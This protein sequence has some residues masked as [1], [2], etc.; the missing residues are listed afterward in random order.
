MSIQF[1]RKLEKSSLVGNTSFSHILQVKVFGKSGFDLFQAR[2]LV[3][4][5]APACT[6]FLLVSMA[7]DR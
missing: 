3:Q 2:A 6:S 1:L 7:C 5:V 4:V